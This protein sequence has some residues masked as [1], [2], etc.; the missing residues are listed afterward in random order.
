MDIGSKGL[1][2]VNLTIPQATSL[3]FTVVHKDDEGD[4]VDHSGSTPHMAFQSKDGQTSYDLS[5]CCACT[6]QAIAI[7]IP[8][9]VT[10]GLPLGKL[11]WDMIVQTQ[12][13]GTIRMCY[14]TVSVVDT[15][16]LDGD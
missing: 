11:V 1:C 2:E 10:G 4:V 15:Y 16:A 3:S 5:D 14:G 12:S 7:N 8:G 9:S 13:G 6:A